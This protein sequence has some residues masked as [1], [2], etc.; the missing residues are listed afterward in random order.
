MET[1]TETNSP[2]AQGNASGS[3]PTRRV[4]PR[5]GGGLYPAAVNLAG[6]NKTWHQMMV[7]KA[8]SSFATDFLK[9]SDHCC[10]KVRWHFHTG[11]YQ[12]C[13]FATLREPC[14]R[15]VSSFA[16]LREEYPKF[17][18]GLASTADEYVAALQVHWAQVLHHRVRMVGWDRHLV[19]AM[20]Q[21]LWIGNS[22]KVMCTERLDEELPAWFREIGCC[23]VATIA[24]VK[25]NGP[26]YRSTSRSGTLT[27]SQANLSEASCA[28]VRE[29]YSEDWLLYQRLCGGR[30]GL[31]KRE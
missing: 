19:L 24:E 28:A 14:S 10:G 17:W 20:P 27:P 25:A 13:S 12:P 29:L 21:H 11:L 4:P 23:K 15:A 1:P 9:A 3:V 8:G 31:E 6:C 22:S 2:S 30:T 7:P 18:P 26:S 16:H 5:R